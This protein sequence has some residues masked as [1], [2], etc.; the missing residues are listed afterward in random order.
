MMFKSLIHITPKRNIESILKNG[1]IPCY[2]KT[3]LTTRHSDI[4][5][6]VWLT[7]NPTYILKEQAGKNWID[8]N[9]PM[10][11]EVNT[12]ELTIKQRVTNCTGT[13]VICPHEYYCESPIFQNFKFIECI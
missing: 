1:L 13:D 8:N 7:D 4:L 5:Y 10:L 2:N 6:A 12:N 9:N 11:I 3:G